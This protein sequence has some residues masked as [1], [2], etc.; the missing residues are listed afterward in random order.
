MEEKQELDSTLAVE[1]NQPS[2]WSPPPSWLRTP[3]TG[4]GIPAPVQTKAQL[5]PV[6]CLAWEDFERLCLRLIEL[7]SDNVQMSFPSPDGKETAPVAGLYGNPGQ[8]QFGI[9][10]YARDRLTLGEAQPQRR[11]ACLQARRIKTVTKAGLS[12]SVDD[13]LKGR[14][15]DVSRKFGYATSASAKSTE[16]VNESERLASTLSERSIEFAVWDQEEI[17]RQLKGLPE[18]VDDFF[19]RHWVE[20]FC[21]EAAKKELGNRLDTHQVAKLRGELAKIYAASFGIADSGLIAFR[22]SEA[23]PA[24]ILE[25]FVTPDLVSTTPQTASLPQPIEDPTDSGMDEQDLQDVVLDADPWNSFDRDGRT[26]A[27][28]KS[29]RRQGRVE[30]PQVFE[31]RSADQWIGTESSHVIVGDPGSGKSTLLRYLILDLL[32]TEPTWQAVAERWGQRLPV[33]LPFHFFT[34]RVEG[35]TG[36]PAS[37]GNALKAWLEQHDAGHTWPLI[38][39]AL[40]DQRLLL[41]VDGLDEWVNDEAGRYALTA[42]QTFAESRSIPLIVSTRPYGLDRLTLGAGWNY[43]R[44][45]PLTREQQRLLSFH[46]FRAVIDTQDQS[47]SPSV[48]ER[49]VD[50]FLKQIHDIPDL[51]AISG[52]PLFLVL[53]IALRLSHS[54]SLP[55]DRFEVYEQAVKLL[56]AD[57]PANR[58]VAAS[59]T[60]QRHRLSDRQLRVIL[61]KVAYISQVRGDI[62]TFQEAALR[63]DFICSLRDPDYLAMSA[64]DAEETADELLDVAEGELGIL[65]RHGPAEIG[66]LHRILQEQLVAEYITNQMTPEKMNE[67]FGRYVGDPRWREV[68]LATMR[69]LSRPPE[70]RGVMDVI[71]E[72]ID[73]SPAGLRAREILA[74]VTFGPYDL[75]AED[76]HKNSADIIDAV[77]T[78]PYGPHRARLLDSVCAGLEGV[79]TGAIVQQCLERWT[80]LVRDAS[81]EL[82]SGVAQLPPNGELSGIVC[83]LLTMALCNHRSWVA[84]DSAIAIAKRCSDGCNDEER[85]VLRNDLL[86]IVS[87]PPSGL[88]QAAG[89]IALALEWRNDPLVVNI[90]NEAREHTEESVRLV[91]LCHALGVLQRTLT[92]SPPELLRDCQPLS[93]AERE[94][95]IGH[96]RERNF[97]DLH[98]GLLIAAVSE[99]VR[100]QDQILNDLIDSLA[101]GAGPYHNFDLIWPV[102]LNVC[103]EDDRVIDIVCRQLRSEKHSSLTSMLFMHVEH[104]LASAYPL[105]S[106]HNSRIAGAIE[107]HISLFGPE[108]MPRV[109]LGLAA[110]DRGPV[111]KRKLLENLETSPSPYWAAEALA[112][113]FDDAETNS[114]LNSVLMG[115]HVRASTIAGVATRILPTCQ[116]IPRLMTILRDIAVSEDPSAGRYDIVAF[117]LIQAFRE[118]GIEP[119]L[120]M[121]P[122]VA[123]ALKLMPAKADPLMGDP[124]YDLPQRH[125][126]LTLQR[127]C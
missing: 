27:L 14:W 35:Q 108:L 78:H 5:L 38:E 23:R 89:L 121:E 41:V 101:S 83:K 99:A 96:A 100:G 49:S 115:E 126:L 84:Y 40:Q 118:Q 92:G 102:I 65:V 31:R 81:M 25:R 82:V 47:S 36:A 24:S 8:V 30:N 69:G 103:G 107:E 57:H 55:V 59:V 9:D 114:A 15:A 80:L 97:N 127:L 104:L 19:G 71:R 117:A 76:I 106:P 88:A 113:Y 91:A 93:D 64:L 56:V 1:P 109:V 43:R 20:E 95:L 86:R 17:S 90:L 111:M 4:Y 3:P 122:L 68:I 7:D 18:L 85:E 125:T 62:S 37:V 75:P 42:L 74:E 46:Y 120:E 61:A 60:T 94:W 10:V 26:W 70:L 12:K 53:L 39:V 58:R 77:E 51:R 33:W 73:E 119:G 79:T 52:T 45:A 87:S 28:R 72:H 11:Y 105:E 2:N 67:L 116:V 98:S 29:A 54:A 32:S 13:F 124:R 21:G 63:K 123:E 112:R 44:I 34:Q 110:I 48:I 66:F 22:F 6:H 50:D 16:L